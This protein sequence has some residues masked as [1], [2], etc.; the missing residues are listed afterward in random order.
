MKVRHSFSARHAGH[1]ENIR[2]QREEFPALAKKVIEQ[3][4][5]IL[6]ILDARF[7]LEMKNPELEKIIKQKNKKIIHV[8]NKS[9]LI[10]FE[11]IKPN[12]KKLYPYT[13]ISCKERKGI[14]N[15][16][17]KIKIESKKLGKGRVVVG[18]LGY[19]NTGKSSII[20]ILIG[21][22]SAKT[23][24]EAGFTK[25]LQKLKLSSGIVLM[26]SPGVIPEKDY[27]HK[28]ESMNKYAKVGG[29]SFSQ[30]KDPET[31]VAGL[32]S[33]YSKQIE[34][35][36]NID[37]EGNSEI[38]IE[39]LGRKKNFLKKGNEVDPDRTSRLI[40]QNWQEG[41]IRI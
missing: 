26:D 19:P 39:K 33:E 21:K 15:L 4:D 12:L 31:A 41:K 18:V 9:D 37:A 8:L 24:P 36:Y 10:D 38:L 17:T 2:K 1:I 6:E 30:I 14:K 35:F 25:G 34:N 32:M 22:A 29:R 23:A 11:K 28:Q 13:L 16:R 27:S 40:I 7:A 3:S 20:N 5:I